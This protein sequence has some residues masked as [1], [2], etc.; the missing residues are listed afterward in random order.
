MTDTPYTTALA[1][2]LGFEGGYYDGS[3]ARDPN[4]TNYGVTQDTY[5]LYRRTRREAPRPV[6]QIE[7]PE[8]QEIY[9]SYWT[10][11]SC[12]LLGPKT[13]VCVFDMSINA[14]P[15]AAVKLLQ[16]ALGVTP[17]GE[18]GPKT[19]AAIAVTDDRA[20]AE[21]V[22]WERVRFY[23]DLAKSPRLRPNLLSWVHRV[24]VYRERHLRD[25]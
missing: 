22:A 25:A 8:V 13:A 5:D 20:L 7:W 1:L 3:E 12:D 23:V 10:G 19:R 24:V 14:G 16:R 15:R 9:R 4:P 11:A 21:R 2:T 6:K 18:V 17:D